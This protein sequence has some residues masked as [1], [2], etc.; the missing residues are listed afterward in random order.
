MRVSKKEFPYLG[1]QGSGS[2]SLVFGG[3]IVKDFVFAND[4]IFADMLV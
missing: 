3:G 4:R 1:V 2:S